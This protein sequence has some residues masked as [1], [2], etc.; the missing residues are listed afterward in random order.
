MLLKL[1]IIIKESAIVNKALLY[2][3]KFGPVISCFHAIE[4][5]RGS[6]AGDSNQ[7]SRITDPIGSLMNL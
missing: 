1:M 6:L 5:C 2:L 4:T 7:K 3:F